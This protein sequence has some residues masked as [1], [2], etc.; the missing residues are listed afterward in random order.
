[1]TGVKNAMAQR[2]TGDGLTELGKTAS[3]E[4]LHFPMQIGDNAPLGNPGKVLGI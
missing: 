3:T 1:M 2:E 4:K